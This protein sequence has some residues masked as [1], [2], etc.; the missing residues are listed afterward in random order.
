MNRL[1][2]ALRL[3]TV[4]D[5]FITLVDSDTTLLLVALSPVETDVDSDATLL[6]VALSFVETDVDSDVTLLLVTLSPVEVEIK[7]DRDWSWLTLTASVGLTPAATLVS[8]TGVVAPTPPSVTVARALSSYCT[9]LAAPVDSEATVLLVMLSPVDNE[10]IPIEVDVD[11]ELIAI[12]AALSCEPFTASVLVVETRPAAT[13]VIVRSKPSLPILTV[14][15]ASIP[16]K[17]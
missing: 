11:S 10:L 17:L 2:P 12:I 9:A 5:K 7:V 13:F 16:L 1:L 3:F 8:F 4:V 15:A 14:L 6:L